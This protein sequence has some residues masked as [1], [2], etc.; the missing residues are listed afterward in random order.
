M[1]VRL[2]ATKH[3]TSISHADCTSSANRKLAVFFSI[4]ALSPSALIEGAISND[5]SVWRLES[6][7]PSVPENL[8]RHQLFREVILTIARNRSIDEPLP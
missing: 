6:C 3:E 5:M 4:G 1:D 7:E 8:R 2:S